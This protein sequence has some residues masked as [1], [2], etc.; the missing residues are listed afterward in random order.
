MDM[1]TFLTAVLMIVDALTSKTAKN[2][3]AGA[4]TIVLA[5]LTAELILGMF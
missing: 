2:Y 4:L 5:I 1:E 3:Y